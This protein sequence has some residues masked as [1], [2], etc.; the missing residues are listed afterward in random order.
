[1]CSYLPSGGKPPAT[2]DDD[3]DGRRIFL[4]S[5]E[6]K[7]SVSGVIILLPVPLA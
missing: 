3:D 6:D 1:M 5:P 2:D 4:A 7:D